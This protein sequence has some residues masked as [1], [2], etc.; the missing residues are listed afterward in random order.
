MRLYE[1]DEAFGAWLKPKKTTGPQLMNHADIE[2]IQSVDRKARPETNDVYNL[3]SV[4][5]KTRFVYVKYQHSF[6]FRV[7]LENNSNKAFRFRTASELHKIFHAV[8]Q[9]IQNKNG[10]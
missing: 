7:I 1:L 6:E 2:M 8:I 9:M 3:K 4:H 10:A 5:G